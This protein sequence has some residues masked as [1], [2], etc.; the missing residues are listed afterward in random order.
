MKFADR[1][2]YRFPIVGLINTF[3]GLLVIYLCKIIGL[4]DVVSNVAGYSVGIFVSFFLNKKW[5]FSYRGSNFSAVL[6]FSVVTAVAYVLNLLVVLFLLDVVG[7]N[8]FLA[9]AAAV[10]IYAFATYFGY[11]WFVFPDRMNG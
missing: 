3:I 8:G 4:D 2:I 1:S 5:T 9:Q 7:I 10:P 11:R 6:K